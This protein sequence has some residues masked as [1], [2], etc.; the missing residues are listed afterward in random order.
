MSAF[1]QLSHPEYGKVRAIHHN[2]ALHFV[3]SDVCR[4]FSLAPDQNILSMLSED[5][6]THIKVGSGSG[7][8][9][10]FDGV[11][12]LA[13]KSSISDALDIVRWLNSEVTAQSS[14]GFDD[15]DASENNTEAAGMPA[16][17]NAPPSADPALTP[18]SFTHPEF[19]NLEIIMVDGKEYFPAAECAKALGYKNSSKAI[20]DHCPHVTKRYVGVQTGVKADGSPAVQKIEKSF[21]PEGDLYRLIVRSKLP[22]AEMFER[23]VFDEVLPTIRKHGAYMTTPVLQQ[24]LGDPNSII[25]LASTLLAEH[26][27]AEELKQQVGEQSILIETQS[28]EISEMR[29][30]VNYLDNILQSSKS[31]PV[32]IIAKD[33]GMSAV[34][35]NALL[36]ELGIQYRCGKTWLLYSKYASHGYTSS[37]LAERN[38]EPVSVQTNWTQKGRLFLYNFLKEKRDLIPV[39]EREVA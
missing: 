36:N 29:P 9:V 26:Q 6:R 10:N 13:V 35:F 5:Q 7:Y 21:I 8:I 11:T 30:K 15:F 16:I 19:G 17:L 18:R 38:G 24:M 4:L 31:M 33:Y 2:N 39:I 22:A 28:R 14:S 3:L 20:S 37:Y 1:T 25:Q 27:R 12:A 32:S 34:A 23:W